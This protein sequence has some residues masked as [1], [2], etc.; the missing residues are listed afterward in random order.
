MMINLFHEQTKKHGRD[1]W[2]KYLFA[3]LHRAAI[4]SNIG[5][6]S[7]DEPVVRDRATEFASSINKQIILNEP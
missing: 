5:A 6:I 7:A 1:K 2:T 3:C 4:D